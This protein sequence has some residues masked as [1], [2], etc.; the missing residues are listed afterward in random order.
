ME[1]GPSGVH[2]NE[3]WYV[4]VCVCVCVRACVHACVVCRMGV[5]VSV[6]CVCV[7]TCFC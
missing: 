3:V 2:Q 5:D 4:S 7:D 6:V 1:G